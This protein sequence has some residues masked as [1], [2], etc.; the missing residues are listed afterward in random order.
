MSSNEKFPCNNDANHS[1]AT[2]IQ[3]VMSSAAEAKLEAL[4]I[5]TKQ[6]AVIRM[7]LAKMGHP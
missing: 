1:A 5:N 7:T 3:V 4:S 2:N 6:A